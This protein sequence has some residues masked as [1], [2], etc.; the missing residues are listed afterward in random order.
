M[1]TSGSKMTGGTDSVDG[2]SYALVNSAIDYATAFDTL[3]TGNY[4]Y[5][6][7]ASYQSYFVNDGTNLMY[8]YGT[9]ELAREYFVVIP[10]SVSQSI[11]RLE[12]E[13]SVRLFDR[14]SNRVCLNPKGQIF[15]QK[16]KN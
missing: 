6:I 5:V 13:L 10:S 3:A 1:W 12:T 7:S 15:Y 14:T 16:V 9:M 4:T 11:K 2:Y 8:A